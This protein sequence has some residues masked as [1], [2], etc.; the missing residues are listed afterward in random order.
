[1]IHGPYAFGK[2]FVAAL[3]LFFSLANSAF[4][5]NANLANQYYLN[6]DTTAEPLS[7]YAGAELMIYQNKYGISPAQST[8]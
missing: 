2:P 5:Q 6:L 7:L 3:F 8:P 4:G 1:M